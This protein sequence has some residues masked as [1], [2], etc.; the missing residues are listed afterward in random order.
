MN[1]TLR[2]T[3]QL[4]IVLAL[5]L[6]VVGLI[7]AAA[8]GSDATVVPDS[9]NMRHGPGEHYAVI[10]QLARGTGLT[11]LGR[12]TNGWWVFSRTPSGQEGWLSTGYLDVRAD[13]DVM[14]LP[15]REAPADTGTPMD[16]GGNEPE[17]PAEPE[18]PADGGGFPEG[19]GVPAQTVATVNMRTGAGTGY[20]V[21]TTLGAGTNA[22]A[23]GRNASLDWILIRVNGQDGWI[24]WEY[25]T[26]LS[27]YISQLPVSTVVTTPGATAPAG[28]GA[29][30]DAGAPAAMPAPI[31]GGAG[32]SGFGYG[33]HVDSFAY[34]NL[35]AHA[36][37]TWAKRQIRHTMG[38]SGSAAAG[39][40]NQAHGSGFRILLGVVGEPHCV[41]T[42]GC[43]E[44]YARFVGEIASLGPD[45]IEVWNEMYI[46]REWAN[47][48]IDPARYTQL[49]A[50]SYNAIKSANPN[51]AVISGAPAP[52]GAEGA[53]GT[54]AV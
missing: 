7:P 4:L 47:G 15:F 37:M 38:A 25:I 9:L 43:F 34:P 11:L 19:T 40:I 41:T 6:S 51:V 45:A 18:T 52:T 16:P 5:I 36:G 44:D 10:A 1:R 12:D 23:M 20:Q 48:H 33:A 8:Q 2:R 32:L 3:P 28:D 13:L 42:P 35:M 46:D 30:P 50:Q 54:A 14:S 24:F 27:G 21:I 26:L 22:L 31:S 17:V 29:A 49:L 53:F 39:A